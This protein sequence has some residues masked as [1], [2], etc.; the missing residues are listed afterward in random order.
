M[1]KNDLSTL[2]VSELVQEF[3]ALGIEQ[4][5]AVWDGDTE[6][7]NPLFYQ[8]QSVKAEL[9]SRPGDERRALGKLYNHPN[10]QVRL[11]AAR[12]TLAL[13]P[14]EARRII[15]S[16]ANSN[17]RPYAGDAGMCLWAL[18]KGIFKPD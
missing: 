15:E 8:M 10:I 13:A 2:S 7:Y 18:D 1:T 5:K 12:S 16:I 6:R 17:D 4:Y 14:I 11:M 9:K 3:V